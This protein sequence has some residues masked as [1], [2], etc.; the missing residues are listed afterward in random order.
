MT[1]WTVDLVGRPVERFE[2]ASSC[3]RG[4][5]HAPDRRPDQLKPPASPGAAGAA[6]SVS[7]RCSVVDQARSRP[8]VEPHRALAL[9]QQRRPGAVPADGVGTGASC[10]WASCT[11]RLWPRHSTGS[12]RAAR[13]SPRRSRFTPAPTRRSPTAPRKGRGAVGPRERGRG[14]GQ[15]RPDARPWRR[16]G[17]TMR[18]PRPGANPSRRPGGR[19]LA[20][21]SPVLEGGDHLTE[22]AAARPK[23]GGAQARRRPPLQPGIG[24]DHAHSAS[25]RTPTRR[26]H[27]GVR[28]QERS[29][30]STGTERPGRPTASAAQER[31]VRN[32]LE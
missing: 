14:R 15:S 2:G 10:A 12:R 30:A 1:G 26:R 25:L 7:P 19:R 9:P 21:E 4:D 29:T 11:S 28:K 32:R 17:R 16:V 20:V 8:G 23:S 22:R 5:R 18:R 24:Q 27:R 6:S 3:G 13:R 31:P